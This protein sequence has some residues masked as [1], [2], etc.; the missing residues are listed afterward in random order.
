[1]PRSKTEASQV[2]YSLK[3]FRCKKIGV[4]ENT[5][6]ALRFV[7]RNFPHPIFGPGPHSDFAFS[8]GLIFTLVRALIM[9]LHSTIL[10]NAAGRAADDRR[11]DKGIQKMIFYM[12][13]EGTKDTMATSLM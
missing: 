8:L 12:I 1:M 9:G 7:H 4:G 2:E 3:T 10:E 6:A 11:Q 5:T 13:G